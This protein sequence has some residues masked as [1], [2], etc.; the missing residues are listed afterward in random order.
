MKVKTSTEINMT[1]NKFAIPMSD[2]IPNLPIKNAI[3]LNEAIGLVHIINV[4]IL[5][6]K[7]W[8]FSNGFKIT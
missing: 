7:F 6:K 1:P 5:K 3:A 2:A 4:K 8:A